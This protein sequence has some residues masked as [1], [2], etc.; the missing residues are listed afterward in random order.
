[1]QTQAMRKRFGW[2]VAARQYA[3]VYEWAVRERG[4]A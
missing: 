4:G 2:D 1:M 3:D